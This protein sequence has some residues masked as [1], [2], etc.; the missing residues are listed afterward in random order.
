MGCRATM[1]PPTQEVRMA[2]EHDREATTPHD[3][4]GEGAESGDAGGAEGSG[5]AATPSGALAVV[6]F[7]TVTI[8][9]FWFGMY[10]LNMVR[11]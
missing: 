8:A 3:Q 11:N 9:V 4:A 10:A 1:P 5:E 2:L 6:G 7:L